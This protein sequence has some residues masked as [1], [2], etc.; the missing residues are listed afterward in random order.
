VLRLSEAEEDACYRGESEALA[1]K[2]GW[3]LSQHDANAIAIAGRGKH[4][5]AYAELALAA[6]AFARAAA[7]AL[8]PRSPR[9]ILTEQDMAKALGQ[10]L[11]SRIE[12]DR[13]AAVL[14]SISAG[15]NTYIDLGSPV[16][17]GIAVPVVIKTLI[18]G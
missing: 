14:D 5:P 18:F 2:L 4:N 6:G 3:F 13:P 9:I 16:M 8:P 12:E 1:E 7:K 11:S 17:G 10:L 15:E